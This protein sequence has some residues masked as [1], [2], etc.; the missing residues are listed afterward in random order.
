[1]G[2]LGVGVVCQKTTN[3]IEMMWIHSTQKQ[4]M[5]VK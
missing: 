5:P 4:A 1:M 2:G 3:Q